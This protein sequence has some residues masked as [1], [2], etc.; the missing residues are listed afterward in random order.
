MK[1]IRIIV[2]SNLISTKPRRLI[3]KLSAVT[4]AAGK[5]KKRTYPQIKQEE[6]ADQTWDI[7]LR[8]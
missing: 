2:R 4:R 8:I 1:R 5:Q 3:R 6:M 7:V